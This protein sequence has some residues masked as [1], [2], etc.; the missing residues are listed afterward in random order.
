MKDA[1]E[2]T[3]S[4]D[5]ITES[6]SIDNSDNGI[7]LPTPL[8]QLYG[9][10]NCVWKTYGLCPHG[11]KSGSDTCMPEGYCQEM[12]DFLFSLS[13]G[14]DNPTII[15]EKYHLYIQEMQAL[16][17]HKDF[18]KYQDEYDELIESGFYEKDQIS[19]LQMKIHTSKMWWSRLT[20]GIIKGY[21]RVN[22]RDSRKKEDLTVTHKISLTQIH[23]LADAASKHKMIEER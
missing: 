11:Y 22:D 2:I 23:Q 21:S 1:T 8:L 7:M 4:E 6:I 15:N 13:Q 9:C 20:D 17:D 18:I 5:T 14:S 19:M 10:K 16:T 3:N 12:V